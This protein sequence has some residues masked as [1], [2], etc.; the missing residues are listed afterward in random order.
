M[1][2]GAH[3]KTHPDKPA[4]IMGG[5]G[6]VTTYRQLDEASNRCA[7]LFRA[8]GLQAGDGIA[9]LMENHPRYFELTWAAQRAGLYYTTISSQLT[10]PE[11]EYI[12]KDSGAKLLF[13]SHA[14]AEVA[15]DLA[16]RLPHLQA[17]YMLSG[18]LPG[19]EAYE[20]AVNPRGWPA[21]R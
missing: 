2:P 13:T 4:V 15:A 6:E 19:F 20:E 18:T 11:V 12:V 17:R 3:A 21:D 7:Q 16:S 14:K 10:A 1:H 5:S 8:Q 9:I